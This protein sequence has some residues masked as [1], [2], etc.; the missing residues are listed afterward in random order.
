MQIDSKRIKEYASDIVRF[1]EDLYYIKPGEPIKL[2]DWQKDIL[3][4][5]TQRD[6]HGNYNHQISILSMPRQNG[7]SELS[8]ILG[9]HALFFGGWGFEILSVGIGGRSTAKVIFDKARRSIKLNPVLY[10]SIGDQGFLKDVITVPDLNSSWEIK[11]SEYLSSLGRA[12]DLILF[13]EL[14]QERIHLNEGG[15]LWDSLTAGQAAKSNSRVVVT[16][17]VGGQIGKMWDLIRL[18]EKDKKIY[19]FL[20]HENLSPLITQ[21]FLDRRR[22]ELHPS[23][24]K[25]WH[26]NQFFTGEDAFLN[27]DLLDRCFDETISPVLQMPKNRFSI[28]FVDIGIKR[29]SSVCVS[30]YR[31]EQNKIRIAEMKSWSPLLLKEEIKLEWIVDYLGEAKGRLNI[32]KIWMDE[33]QGQQIIQAHGRRLNIEGVHWTADKLEKC[34][35]NFIAVIQNGGIRIYNDKS[36]DIRELRKELLNLTIS[37]KG[38]GFKVSDPGRIHQDRALSLA[39]AVWKSIEG[40]EKARYTFQHYSCLLARKERCPL[41]R[42]DAGFFTVQ[43]KQCDNY[44]EAIQLAREIEQFDFK[45][46]DPMHVPDQLQEFC[47]RGKIGGFSARFMTLDY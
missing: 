29:D 18:V 47:K 24:Y 46:P 14:G 8:T 2:W 21:E 32:Q 23:V 41:M 20:T 19:L 17:T 43:Y 11:S 1:A 26:E 6:K 9:L 28:C 7:K 10:E 35:A 42:P 4:K 45:H 3:R 15:E 16:S 44:F 36:T 12:F 22:E 25:H 39:G 37:A 5:A 38:A 33:W 31:D 27:P 30:V 13:D 40:H 34:W